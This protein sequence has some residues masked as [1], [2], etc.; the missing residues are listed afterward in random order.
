MSLNVLLFL[1]LIAIATAADPFDCC[2]QLVNPSGRQLDI[3][4]N[5]IVAGSSVTG[6][7]YPLHVAID[8]KTAAQSL[9]LGHSGYIAEVPQ[10]TVSTTITLP[11]LASVAGLSN[12]G[13]WQS[14]ILFTSAGDGS[15]NVTITNAE[16][17]ANMEGSYQNA[18]TYSA[19]GSA[20]KVT[21][22][23]WSGAN[24]VGGEYVDLL[25]DGTA[26]YVFANSATAAVFS[27][28]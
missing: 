24:G 9:T 11:S 1:I 15:H 17:K 8:S 3:K 25:C 27:T 14:K 28:S 12:N 26:W 21:N 10:V 2:Q 4:V 13:Y 6:S 7:T 22:F 16:G 5:S 20:G 18:G 19:K 23:I